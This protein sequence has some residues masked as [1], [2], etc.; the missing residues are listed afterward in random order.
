MLQ[1]FNALCIA[2]KY[3]AKKHIA[4]KHS[5]CVWRRGKIDPQSY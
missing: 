4:K 3:I 1:S 5:V 2:K